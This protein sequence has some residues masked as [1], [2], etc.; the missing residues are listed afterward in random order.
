MTCVSTD[1]SLIILVHY[2]PGTCNLIYY[3]FCSCAVDHAYTRNCLILYGVTVC[4]DEAVMVELLA[5]Y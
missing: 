2:L 5:L 1:F 4:E 3:T